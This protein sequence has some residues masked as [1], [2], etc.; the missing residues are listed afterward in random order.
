[1]TIDCGVETHDPYCLCD[2]VI[3]EPVEINPELVIGGTYSD[4]VVR[5]FGTELLDEQDGLLNYMEALA[6]AKDAVERRKRIGGNNALKGL[7]WRDVARLYDWLADGE[8]IIDWPDESGWDWDKTLRHLTKG[9]PSPLWGLE[10]HDFLRIEGI[11]LDNREMSGYQLSKH[12]DIGLSRKS[13]VT[14]RRIYFD[15]AEEVAA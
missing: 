5:A 8:S 3:T 7:D 2:V 9:T 12:T 1:M 11:L 15:L 14:L 10:P 6:D 4:Y 13:C